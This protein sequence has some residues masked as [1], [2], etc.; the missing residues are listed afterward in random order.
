MDGSEQVDD[1]NLH[2]SLLSLAYIIY[3]SLSRVFDKQGL[4]SFCLS[5]HNVIAGSVI[6][7]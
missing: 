1:E 7:E 5:K 2:S 4:Q 3:R 6:S